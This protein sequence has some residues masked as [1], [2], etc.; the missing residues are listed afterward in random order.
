MIREISLADTLNL[1]LHHVVEKKLKVS[2]L[3]REEWRGAT[4]PKLKAHQPQ[5][6]TATA[7]VISFRLASRITFHKL[8]RSKDSASHGP[9]HFLKC[10]ALDRYLCFS[11]WRVTGL[12]LV[13]Y[14][15]RLATT[16]SLIAAL[17]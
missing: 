5:T 15:P 7:N 11:L 6:L 4:G 8:E 17:F 12:S 14:P 2:S 10:Q 9:A 1:T 3:S 13:M 16:Q